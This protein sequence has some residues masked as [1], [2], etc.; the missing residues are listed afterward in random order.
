MASAGAPPSLTY[1]EVLQIIVRWKTEGIPNEEKDA[2]L[3][4]AVGVA[5]SRSGLQDFQQIISDI[6]DSA[7]RIDAAF[8][9]VD[10]SFDW[11]T[12]LQLIIQYPEIRSYYS[13]W[14]GYKDVST[15]D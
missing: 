7:K 14:R 9:E 1:D 6:A 11:I 4:A 2:F 5:D 13:Q 8:D 12:T 15:A 3:E 10:S